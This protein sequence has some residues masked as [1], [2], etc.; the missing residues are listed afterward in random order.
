MPSDWANVTA[1]GLA[2][3]FY[4]SSTATYNTDNKYSEVVYWS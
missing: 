1:S 3:G 4:D 2:G